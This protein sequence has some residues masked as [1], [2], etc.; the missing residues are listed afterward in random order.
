MIALVSLVTLSGGVVLAGQAPRYPAWT[1]RM[2]TAGGLALVTG[3][4]MVGAGL[5]AYC[6]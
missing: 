1:A 5:K 2:E 6:C 4:A 3:L